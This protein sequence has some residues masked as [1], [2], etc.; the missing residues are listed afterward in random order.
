MDWRDESIEGVVERRAGAGEVLRRDGVSE[1]GDAS[2]RS[3]RKRRKWSRVERWL[4]EQMRRPGAWLVLGAVWLVVP[5]FFG[6]VGLPMGWSVGQWVAGCL[7]IGL[8]Y[9]AVRRH[10]AFAPAVMMALGCAAS[11]LTAVAVT[12]G[13]SGSSGPTLWMACGLLGGLILLETL[14]DATWWPVRL[15][16]VAVATGAVLWGA[17]WAVAGWALVTAAAALH[18]YDAARGRGG[19]AMAALGLAGMAVVALGVA[20][21]GPASVLGGW[22]AGEGGAARGLLAR[23]V[24]VGLAWGGVGSMGGWAA[25]SVVWVVA[26]VVAVAAWPV[27]VLGW[28]A[29][30]R[31]S[32]DLLVLVCPWGALL[33]GEGSGGR[34]LML[35]LLPIAWLTVWRVARR[36]RKRRLTL[37]AMAV[38]VQLGLTL[39]MMIGPGLAHR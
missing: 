34:A 20:W 29:W 37:M 9:H 19:W 10:V 25:G 38:A 23:F 31:R 27:L 22:F 17:G 8:G 7:Y 21:V 2:G 3:G 28:W 15:A 18:L 30:T 11:W 4:R 12:D 1:S 32:G 16:G 33:A 13:W 36:Y 6:G 14:R 35:A 26:V 5:A 24:D 39:A